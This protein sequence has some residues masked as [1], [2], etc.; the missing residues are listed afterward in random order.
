[1]IRSRQVKWVA[2][3]AILVACGLFFTLFT[4]TV[5]AKEKVMAFG[6]QLVLNVDTG[7]PANIASSSQITVNNGTVRLEGENSYLEYSVQYPSSTDFGYMMVAIKGDFQLIGNGTAII[8]EV[9][10]DANNGAYFKFDNHHYFRLDRFINQGKESVITIR[11]SVKEGGSNAEI[12]ALTF[13]YNPQMGNFDT[14]Y[15]ESYSVY[16]DIVLAS[17]QNDHYMAEQSFLGGGANGFSEQ[18]FQF[19]DNNSYGV[20][21]FSYEKEATLLRLVGEFRS[22][23]R[24]SA[25]TDLTHWKDLAIAPLECN[26]H[27]DV[28]SNQG[29][30]E[31]DLTDYKNNS[32]EI[33]VK[34]GDCTTDA[35]WGG[36]FSQMMLLSVTAGDAGSPLP[37]FQ[38]GELNTKIDLLNAGFLYKNNG[39]QPAALGRSVKGSDAFFV[40][41]FK[42]P[43]DS[44]SFYVAMNI[45]DALKV[46]LSTDGINYSDIPATYLLNTKVGSGSATT[47][48]LK[49]Y[50]GISKT[51][52]LK[53]SDGIITDDDAGTLWT[54]YA[55]YNRESIISNV[56]TEYQDKEYQGFVVS[57]FEEAKYWMNPNEPE[58][59][60]TDSF[61]NVVDK[62]FR[63]NAE[64]IYKFQ[65]VENAKAVK[66]Y[67]VI[68]NS[69]VLSVSKDGINY[70]D[71]AIAEQQFYDP[72]NANTT[73]EEFYFDIT[74]FTKENPSRT[75]YIK[76]TDLVDDNDFGASLR[77]LGI[78]SM[79]GDVVTL[80]VETGE[81]AD[82]MPGWGIALIIV[83]GV[84]VI[85]GAVG[86]IMMRHKRNKR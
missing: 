72:Y 77:S 13:F 76:I 33:Y 2:F 54:L 43:S 67:A 70:T 3:C 46:Q 36:Q 49:S 52:Y 15:P 25:S 18:G 39:S 7:D 83:A 51:I 24:I 32:G 81:P 59:S 35:G 29:W 20:Y 86:I 41:Q 56:G 64:G 5:Y 57:D 84:A 23:Y 55:G 85:V 37:I 44:V 12:S 30:Y 73:L 6:D 19:Y 11:C 14:L 63:R 47:Y 66:L 62:E 60:T 26:Y 53:F 40:Y 9:G 42:L 79:S 68:A 27:Q 16:K 1:M 28:I 78:V 31:F 69:F 21:R 58:V 71:M 34:I 38:E 65:Y 48:N 82:G 80:S 50:L 61:G 17:D 22:G 75:I 8:G 74:E 45:T 4:F 10:L